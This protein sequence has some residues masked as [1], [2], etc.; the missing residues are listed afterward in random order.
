MQNLPMKYKENFFIKI[1]RFFVNL[2]N[3][4]KQEDFANIEV[5]KEIR[6][7]PKSNIFDKMHKE[8]VKSENEKFII[9]KTLKNRD[10]IKNLSKKNLEKLNKLYDDRI[11]ENNRI[12]C[13]NSK[14][15]TNLKNKLSEFNS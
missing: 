1:K 14:K 13:D 2:L 10:T 8:Y 12:I 15:I 5:Q 4:Q 9:E 11:E 6:D 3:K 7:I